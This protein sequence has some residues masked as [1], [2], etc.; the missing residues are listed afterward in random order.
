MRIRTIRSYQASAIDWR[1]RCEH[2]LETISYLTD[3]PSISNISNL[4]QSEQKSVNQ[5]LMYQTNSKPQLTQ[6]KPDQYQTEIK[7]SL[8]YHDTFR[9]QKFKLGQCD[10]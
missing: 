5:S 3:A 6:A 4:H 2:E 8:N 7:P 10:N 9:V 1:V